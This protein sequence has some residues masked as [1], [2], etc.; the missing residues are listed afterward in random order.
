MKVTFSALAAL[1]LAA[2]AISTPETAEAQGWERV[3]TEQQFRDRIVDRRIVTPE[4][5]SFT[6]HADGSVTGQW[7]GQP[8]VGGWQWY[9]GMWCRNVRVGQSPEIG[10]D[11]QLIELLGN[12]IRSTR[13]QGRGEPGVGHLE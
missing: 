9:Q 10:T 13:D 4:G 12:E 8:M 11:C 5:N 6:P 3:I 2:A 1:A 7:G